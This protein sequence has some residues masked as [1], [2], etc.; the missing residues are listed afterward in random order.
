MI[1]AER[2]KELSLGL[3]ES[4]NL[5]EMLSIDLHILLKRC[6]PDV[7]LPQFE[8]KAGITKKMYII[9]G[10]LYKQ[11][12]FEVFGQLSQHKSDVM[13]GLACYLLAHSTDMTLAE[14]LSY[15]LAEDS[16][17]GVREWAWIAIRRYVIAEPMRALE[18]LQP[19]TKKSSPNLRRFASEITRPRGVWCS[20][21]K[22]FREQPW[23]ALELLEALHN[24]DAKY[25]QLS[26]ANWLNDAGKDH[27]IWVKETCARWLNQSNTA[28]TAKICKRALR[29]LV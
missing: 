5:M 11:Y 16:N 8:P 1:S 21:I 15:T 24:D 27:P 7:D 12:G 22:L 3:D 19:Y 9:A 14:R 6:F 20:H 2:I 25:V 26:V 29:N 28:N 23:L 17:A 18:L 4:R 13:R 10:E